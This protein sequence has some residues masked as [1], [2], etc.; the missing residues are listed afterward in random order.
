MNVETWIGFLEI[1]EKIALESLAVRLVRS[2][3]DILFNPLNI[4]CVFPPHLGPVSKLSGK[5]LT[6]NCEREGN[7]YIS[8]FISK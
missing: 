5:I 7:L 1:S 6:E 3:C 4:F 8:A 2:L